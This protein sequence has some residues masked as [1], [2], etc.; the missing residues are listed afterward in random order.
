MNE[1]VLLFVLSVVI[2]KVIP[3]SRNSRSSA[4]TLACDKF[5][6]ATEPRTC[7]FMMFDNSQP[8]YTSGCESDRLADVCGSMR[9]LVLPLG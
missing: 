1:S 9:T 7:R 4:E 8:V 5:E 3:L 2:E 6:H